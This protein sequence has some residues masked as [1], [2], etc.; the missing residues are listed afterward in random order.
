MT[1][2]FIS[3]IFQGDDTDAFGKQYIRINTPKG[4]DPTLITKLIFQCGEAQIVAEKPSFPYY[5][6]LT[7]E[8][9]LNLS[10]RNDCYVQLFDDVGKRITLKGNLTV[11]VDKKPI[12]DGEC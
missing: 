1:E 5:I 7:H 10:Y 9:T 2:Q 3:N 6:N 12:F 11:L 8:Q 4:I